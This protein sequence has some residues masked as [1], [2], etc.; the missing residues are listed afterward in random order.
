MEHCASFIF[1]WQSIP[2]MIKQYLI[3][4]IPQDS[5]F[6]GSEKTFGEGDDANYFVKSNHFPQQ[7]ALLGLL[8]YMVLE[9]EGRLNEPANNTESLIGLKGFPAT[10][11]GKIKSLSPLFI[12]YEEP[13]KPL[14]NYIVQAKDWGWQNDRS[15]GPLHLE[16]NVSD[17]IGKTIANLNQLFLLKGFK[18]KNELAPLLIEADGHEWKIFDF[19]KEEGDKV[20]NGVFVPHQKVGIKK[21]YAFDAN[22]EKGNRKGNEDEAFYR[23]TLY[24]L[25]PYYSFAFFAS[26]ETG[27]QDNPPIKEGLTV[28]GAE[29]SPFV[30]KITNAENNTLPDQLFDQLFSKHLAATEKVKL[31]SHPMLVLM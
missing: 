5:F 14:K 23:Q 19:E 9:K 24:K 2:T 13:G 6:F 29:K 3:Q 4:L 27:N 20:N 7:T 26:F 17:G 11:Y 30:V 16:L 25:L 28:F 10:G 31:S 22:G 18:A 1:Y 15:N 8:R 21:T 12:R